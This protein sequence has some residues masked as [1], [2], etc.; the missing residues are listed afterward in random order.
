MSGKN[1]LKLAIPYVVYKYI[2]TKPVFTFDLMVIDQK[3]KH[4]TRI[5]FFLLLYTRQSGEPSLLAQS[6]GL[7]ACTEHA[8]VHFNF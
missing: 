4:E 2:D 8:T 5:D 3:L 1:D 7:V 6:A